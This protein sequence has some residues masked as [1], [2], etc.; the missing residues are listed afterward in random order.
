M[1]NFQAYEGPPKSIK[2]LEAELLAARKAEE[3][4]HKAR[5]QSVKPVW[6][7]TF[8]LR[9][10]KEASWFCIRKDSCVKAYYLHG[11]VVNRAELAAVGNMPGRHEDGGMTYL[12]NTATPTPKIIKADGGGRYFWRDHDLEFLLKDIEEFLLTNPEGGD[13]TPFVIAL[14]SFVG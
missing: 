14:P 11:A 1:Q 8:T 6:K 12:V 13:I 5:Q 7:F 3:E 4:A 9:A 10:G 2:Q